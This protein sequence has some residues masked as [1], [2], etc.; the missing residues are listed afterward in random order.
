MCRYLCR[1]TSI[2]VLPVS[3][4][5][6]STHRPR[7]LCC[8]S[9][10]VTSFGFN[11]IFLQEFTLYLSMTALY[12]KEIFKNNMNTEIR[13]LIVRICLGFWIFWRRFL[14]ILILANL[15]DLLSSNLLTNLAAHVA[16]SLYIYIYIPFSVVFQN[17]CAI[18]LSFA[19]IG[20]YLPNATRNIDCR[21]NYLPYMFSDAVL[22]S[23]TL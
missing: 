19:V 8:A 12:N 22:P 21:S 13:I 4:Y 23:A 16:H 1:K 7:I 11:I 17:W 10:V 18:D 2:E 9:L 6:F 15:H 14:K 5:K 20:M 3:I